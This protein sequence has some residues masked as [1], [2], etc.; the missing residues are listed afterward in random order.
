MKPCT[1]YLCT[2][3]CKDAVQRSVYV[4]SYGIT[5]VTLVII[6]AVV[7]AMNH[8][9]HSSYHMTAT[10]LTQANATRYIFSPDYRKRYIILSTY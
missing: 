7:A 2:N 3:Y 5:E 4:I 8:G 1:H 6:N 9:Q 10:A